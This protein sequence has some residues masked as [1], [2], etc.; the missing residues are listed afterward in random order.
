MVTLIG[1]NYFFL[2][3]HVLNSFDLPT[4]VALDEK[5]KTLHYISAVIS[6]SQQSNNTRALSPNAPTHKV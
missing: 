6:C 4:G 1:I 2:W 3:E 5:A